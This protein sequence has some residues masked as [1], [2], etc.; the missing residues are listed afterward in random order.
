M[1]LLD[2]ASKTI[3]SIG[4]LVENAASWTVRFLGVG[5]RGEVLAAYLVFLV[6]SILE[7]GT[8]AGI[9]LEA[10]WAEAFLNGLALSSISRQSLWLGHE[11]F[12]VSAMIHL[13]WKFSDGPIGM[14][15][16]ELGRFLSALLRRA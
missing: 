11:M 3:G 14:A 10:Q 6:F 13:Q 8:W 5:S 2:L 7:I 15:L 9:A 16:R 1:T 12:L 4:K